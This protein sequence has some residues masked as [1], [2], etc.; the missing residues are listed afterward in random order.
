MRGRSPAILSEA[1]RLIPGNKVAVP[2]L[3]GKKVEEAG[4]PVGALTPQAANALKDTRGQRGRRPHRRTNPAYDSKTPTLV[5]SDTIVNVQVG[6][7]KAV[8]HPRQQR[9]LKISLSRRR[10]EKMLLL[11]L[12]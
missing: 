10:R 3:Q 6:V 7:A 5:P 11:Y 9:W 2:N 8:P 4:G 12:G 1:V